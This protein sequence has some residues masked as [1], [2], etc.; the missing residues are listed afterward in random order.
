VLWADT[1]YIITQ[2]KK[3]ATMGHTA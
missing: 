1:N 2:N 3:Y